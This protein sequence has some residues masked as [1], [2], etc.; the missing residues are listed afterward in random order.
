M[1]VEQEDDTSNDENNQK[2]MLKTFHTADG[3]KNQIEKY[4]LSANPI[5]LFLGNMSEYSFEIDWQN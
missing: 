5:F 2:A 3:A 4:L 1:C